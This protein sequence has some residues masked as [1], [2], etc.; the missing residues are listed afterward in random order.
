MNVVRAAPRIAHRAVRGLFFLLALGGATGSPAAAQPALTHALRAGPERAGGGGIDVLQRPAAPLYD[1]VALRVEFQPDTS[2]FTTG[3]GTFSDSLYRGLEVAIDPLPHDA[4]YFEAHLAFL[5]DY[6]ARVS[7]GQTAVQTHLVPEV[8]RVA[9]PMGAYSPTG[10]DADSDAEVAKLAALVREA[11]ALADAQ[12]AFDLSGFDPNTTAFVLFHAGAGRDIELTGTTLDRTPLD[13]PSLSFDAAAL[14]RLTPGPPIVFNGFE[15]TNTLV[16]PETESRLGRDPFT[17]QDFVVEFSI[18]G[19]L[20]ASF[21]SYLGVPDLFNTETG[22]SAIGPF[23]LMDP[24]GIFSFNGLFPPEPEAWTKQF[25]AWVEPVEAE[26]A[27]PETFTLAA[28]SAMGASDAVRVPVSGAEY[29]LVENR[30]RAAEA[31]ELV[32]TIYRDGA[33]TEQRIALGAE[34]FDRFDTSAFEGGVVVAADPY[35]WA[36]PGLFDASLQQRFDGGIVIWHVDERVLRETIAGNRV[37]ADPNRRGVDVEEADGAQDIGFGTGALAQGTP[38]DVWFLDN[39]VTAVTPSGDVRLYRNRFGP[40]TTPSSDSNDGGPSFVVLEDFSAPGPEMTFTFHRTSA[41]GITP[42][43]AFATLQAGQE[44]RAGGAAKAFNPRE[45]PVLAV[46]T[47]G[48]VFPA[49]SHFDRRTGERVLVGA[50]PFTLPAEVSLQGVGAGSA[51]FGEGTAVYFA[52]G[53]ALVYNLWQ[54]PMGTFMGPTVSLGN[55]IH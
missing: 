47:P 55:V 52:R 20:A 54:G 31:D 37:N 49:Y 42:L 5:E 33:L 23:G 3:G 17:Q 28:V 51:A 9:Q 29:F 11:W 30:Q 48:D 21:F 18:N 12:S 39:P 38:F 7:D 45:G 43:E 1:V 50:G 10:P 46:Y 22:E 41:A 4:A 8:I 35:D 16:L 40:D 25:L 32:L 14:E 27:G 13:L 26:G 36:L 44:V 24:L 53:G 19:L 6:V 15:V 34:G 2:R